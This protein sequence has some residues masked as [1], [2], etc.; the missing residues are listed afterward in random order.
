MWFA[1]TNLKADAEKWERDYPGIK[2]ADVV[3][4]EGQFLT[5]GWQ[6]WPPPRP[7]VPTPA[8]WFLSLSHQQK[9]LWK[10]IQSTRTYGEF[11]IRDK[12]FLDSKP[13]VGAQMAVYLAGELNGVVPPDS[14]LRAA[15]K[16]GIHDLFTDEPFEDMF[17]MDNSL[18]A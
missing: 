6:A 5:N 15:M 8:R 17:R 4:P 11:R 10:E 18:P 2:L 14:S 16:P 9:N 13:P 3:Y 1:D 12:E 7:T